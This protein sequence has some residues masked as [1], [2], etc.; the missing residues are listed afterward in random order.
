VLRRLSQL[1]KPQRIDCLLAI[2]ELAETFGQPHGHSGLSIRK[3]A[4][5]VFECR[6]NLDLRL[7]FRDRADDLFIFLFGDHDEVR[8]AMKSGKI[9]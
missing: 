1:P 8:A 3:L 9:G 7:I 4:P 5:K 6:G 2:T